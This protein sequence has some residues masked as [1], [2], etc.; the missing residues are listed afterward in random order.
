MLVVTA[1]LLLLPLK[2]TDAFSGEAIY[3]D[4]QTSDYPPRPQDIL[5]MT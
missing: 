4:F 2:T 1:T 3:P 5:G